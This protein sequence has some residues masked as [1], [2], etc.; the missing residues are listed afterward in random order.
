[1]WEAVGSERGMVSVLLYSVLRRPN[2]TLDVL[3]LRFINRISD[4]HQA[5][6]PPPF[7]GGIVADPMG[8]GKTLTM[9]ALTASDLDSK[10][11]ETPGLDFD[12]SETP[13]VL[14]TLIVIPP[15]RA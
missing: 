14:A 15:P 8:L 3:L 6:E 11:Y 9:I 10:E 13:P 12:D 1:M 2:L 5:D 7:Y 4:V